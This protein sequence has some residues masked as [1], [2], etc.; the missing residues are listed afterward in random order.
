[1]NLL[2]QL[3]HLGEE[4]HVEIKEFQLE[5]NRLFHKSKGL[6]IPNLPDLERGRI[7]NLPRNAVDVSHVIWDRARDDRA[8]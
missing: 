5:R 4:G 2:T 6:F 8:A 7:M 3:S 1:M